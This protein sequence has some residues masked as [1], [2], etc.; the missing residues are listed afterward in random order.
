M[1]VQAANRGVEVLPASVAVH[2]YTGRVDWWPPT[3]SVR[4]GL[5]ARALVQAA[6][7][8]LGKPFAVVPLLAL[9]PE[10]GRGLGPG[11]G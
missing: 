8:E 6:F 9:L 5:D 7:D 3:P 2:R 1:F 11:Q 10:G 4:A